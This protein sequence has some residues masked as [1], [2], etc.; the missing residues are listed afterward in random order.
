MA[1]PVPDRY[2]CFS[3]DPAAVGVF[4]MAPHSLSVCIPVHSEA[5]HVAAPRT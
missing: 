4:S 1:H 3:V 5:S 2:P